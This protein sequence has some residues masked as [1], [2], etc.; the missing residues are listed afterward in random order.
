MDRKG[1]WSI[2]IEDWKIS[3]GRMES[4]GEIPES[5]VMMLTHSLVLGEGSFRMS[6]RAG[7][8]E[9]GESPGSAGFLIGM[10]DDVDHSVKSVCYFGKGI[11]A[12]VSMEGYAFLKDKRLKLPEDFNWDAFTMTV[13]GDHDKLTLKVK[14]SGGN[15]PGMFTCDADSL[16]GL[17]GDCG[18]SE[19]ENGQNGSSKFWF[20]DWRLSGTKWPK[21]RTRHSDLC[22]G[23]CIPLAKIR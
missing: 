17:I 14:D 9:K 18:Q 23:R 5:R 6:V 3:G 19:V 20:D 10:D 15:S 7:L 16:K 13:K 1:F 11:R 8:L 21:T 22:Y 2:P 4:T 12:G